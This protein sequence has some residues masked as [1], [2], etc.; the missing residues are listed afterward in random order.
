[1]HYCE[2]TNQAVVKAVDGESCRCTDERSAAKQ[3]LVHAT[4][5]HAAA[6]T[7]LLAAG[8]ATAGQLFQIPIVDALPST[9]ALGGGLRLT[10]SPYVD[11]ESDLDLVPLY[12]Y[13]GK[14]L[15]AHGTEFGAHLF[16][17]DTFSVDAIA[18]YNFMGLEPEPLSIEPRQSDYFE[19]LTER[20]STLDGGLSLGMRGGWGDLQLEW[21]HDL[22]NRSDGEEFDLTYRYRWDVGNWMFSPFVTLAWQDDSLTG[23]YYGVS[24]AEAK[25]DR[26]AY[27]PGNAK[28]A[29]FGLNTWYQL[30]DQVFL[31]GN[32]GFE[33]VDQKIL[34]SPLVD[35]DYFGTGVFI[36][37][38]YLFGGTR[39]SPPREPSER[40]GEW[41]WR[42]N[43]GYAAEEN[44][45]PYLMAGKWKRSDEA[46]TEIAGITLGKLLMGGPRVD[47]YGKL[48][49][50]R[51][52]EHPYQS[53][54]WDYAGYVMAMAKGYL[55]WSEQP[56]FRY[57]FG[58]GVSYA[59]K[60]PAVE[61]IKQ[62]K[63]NDN[64]SRLLNYLEFQADVPLSLFTESRLTRNC[65]AGVTMAH[66]SGIFGTADILGNVSG[67]ADW[68]T[69]HLE[70]LR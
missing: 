1:M 37:A 55:P 3:W 52:F 35:D 43:A 45:F 33:G 25:P 38:G 54:F 17:N 70:C 27:V 58:F 20:Q 48:A 4:R 26:P 60:V 29:S 18:S 67:G 11:D 46:N 21:R 32:L 34:D 15:F 22:L 9:P 31:F 51:H 68:V 10:R 24:D 49:L 65:Y 16:R 30:T 47:F 36:G 63:K 40:A 44:I 7:L 2:R 56:A 5:L 61:Q 57:G 23:Y 66:R 50:Y 59:E 62:D 39:R 14:Y 53:N 12:L 64:T 28:N 69:F 41:S 8:A 13:E 6:L 42:V 19:G